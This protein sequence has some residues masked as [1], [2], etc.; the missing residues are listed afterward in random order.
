MKFLINYNKFILEKIF[1]PQPDDVDESIVNKMN[2]VN[3]LD[4]WIKEY[5]T[6]KNKISQIFQNYKDETEKRGLL[7]QF[8]KDSTQPNLIFKNDLL[9][10]WAEVCSLKRKLTDLDSTVKDKQENIKLREDELQK[11]SKVKLNLRKK[12]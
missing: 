10:L 9:G 1:T 3:Q 7:K 5:P 6:Q 11:I 2:Q 4:E 8:L 12:N